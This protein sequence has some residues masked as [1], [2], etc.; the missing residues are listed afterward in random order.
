MELMALCDGRSVVMVLVGVMK[1]DETM[2]TLHD[3]AI[4]LFLHDRI[5]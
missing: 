5:R 4:I 1:C 3:S 2:T